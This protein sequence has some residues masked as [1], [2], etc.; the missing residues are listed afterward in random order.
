M[1]THTYICTHTH[2][3]TRTHTHTHI[4]TVLAGGGGYGSRLPS[5]PKT[6]VFREAQ[7]HVR[8]RLEKKWVTV[9]ITTP[10]YLER[11]RSSIINGKGGTK[12]D[13]LSQAPVVCGLYATSVTHVG[14][15]FQ[16]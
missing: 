6:P 15:S 2:T 8:A 12:A 1:H 16:L 4:Q 7:K 11:N 3:H 13:G 10:E 5:R 14:R 9:F